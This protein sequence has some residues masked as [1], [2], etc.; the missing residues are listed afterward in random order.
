MT[1]TTRKGIIERLR[2]LRRADAP[3]CIIRNAQ[4]G[5]AVI[6]KGYRWS[7]RPSAYQRMLEQRY[8]ESES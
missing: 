1:P 2:K 3:K 7:H 6:R 5:A 8:K 4:I